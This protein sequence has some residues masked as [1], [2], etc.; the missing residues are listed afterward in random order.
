MEKYKENPN[1][2]ILETFVSPCKKLGWIPINKI[3][4]SSMRSW[5][6]NAGWTQQDY[7]R[8]IPH[9]F[10]IRDPHKR[11]L[12]GITECVNQTLVN[13]N[14]SLQT[15]FDMLKRNKILQ[16]SH[17]MSICEILVYNNLDYKKIICLSIDNH[18]HTLINL[19]FK[20]YDV[21]EIT[22]PIPKDNLTTHYKRQDIQQLAEKIYQQG[23]RYFHMGLV[24]DL[25]IYNVV[26]QN[27]NH[28]RLEK[29]YLNNTKKTPQF[30]RILNLSTIQETI[31]NAVEFSYIDT[32]AIN[33]DK[34]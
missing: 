9:F 1:I 10:L 15:Q 20:H 28:Y 23:F 8:N 34:T 18:L 22:Q 17:T 11:L 25:E 16:D 2:Q 29:N 7:D 24:R 14:I 3:A 12:S 31:K 5:L 4:S 27:T 32:D 19:M 21:A 33:N 6:G 30:E 13:E 26:C